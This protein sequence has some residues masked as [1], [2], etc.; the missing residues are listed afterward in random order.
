V[1]ELEV[2]IAHRLGFQRTGRDL[3]EVTLTVVKRQVGKAMRPDEDGSVMLI[4]S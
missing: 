3:Q 4:W 2:E 1:N